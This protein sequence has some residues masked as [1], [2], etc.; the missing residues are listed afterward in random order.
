MRALTAA[1]LAAAVSAC[2][3]A[4]QVLPPVSVTAIAETEPVAQAAGV[5][6]AD[7]P[8]IWRNPA[9]PAASLIVGTDK[10]GG[11]HVYGLDGKSRSFAQAGEVNNVDL[12]DMGPVSQGGAGVIVVASDRNDLTRAMLLVYRLDTASGQLAL[13]GKVPGGAGEGYGLCLLKQGQRLL[14]YSVLKQGAI[15]EYEL[16]LGAAPSATPL[17]ILRVPSQPEGCVADQRSG[18]LYVGEEAGG[19]WRFAAGATAG[20]LV[21]PVDNRTLVADVE[22]LALL[23]EGSEGGYL[24]ASSQGDNA[25]AVFRLPDLAPLGRF[26]IAAGALGGAEETDGIE[27]IGGS[28]GPEYPEGLFVAQDGHNQPLGQNFKLV[29]W[30]AI[31]AALGL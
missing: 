23:P 9:D 10:R 7:D 5:D 20:D 6:A 21:L 12:A 30:A 15:H 3:S 8:A 14:A 17:R 16:T 29:S 24:V 19:I 4:P 18:T 31:K 26:A 27:L 2:A 25:Y 22:G 1:A 11:V 28:F 13:L